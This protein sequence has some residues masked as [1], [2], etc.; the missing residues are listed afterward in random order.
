MVS[1]MTFTVSSGN[2]QSTNDLWANIKAFFSDTPLGLNKDTGTTNIVEIPISIDRV[3]LPSTTT[4]IQ[5]RL[6]ARMNLIL[7]NLEELERTYPDPV[8]SLLEIIEGLPPDNGTWQEIK[9]EP[10]G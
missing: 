2:Q 6:K 9:D 5:N 7:A 3:S 1:E 4:E 8:S 10:Y